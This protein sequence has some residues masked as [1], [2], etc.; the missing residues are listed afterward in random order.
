MRTPKIKNI[1]KDLSFFISN[2]KHCDMIQRI[3]HA[4]SVPE[5]IDIL[6]GLSL[7]SS[8]VSDI[9]QK[10]NLP[11]S[12]V[13]RH[14]DILE[15]AKLVRVS[16][17]PTKKGHIKY[18]SQNLYSYRV[19]VIDE[20]ARLEP[21][22]DFTTEMPIG[23]FSDIS[24]TAPCGMNSAESIIGETV[25]PDIFYLPERIKAER[26][27]FSSGHVT[28]RF[29]LCPPHQNYN[30]I[31]FSFEI[32]SE[33]FFFNP[34]WPSDVTLSINDIEVATIHLIGD[35]GGRLGKYTPK[36]WS[37]NNS[38]FGVLKTVTVNSTGVYI[39]QQP[40]STNVNF[41]KLNL[42]DKNY[43]T[44]T[45]AVKENAVHKGGLN[46]YGKN[47]GDYPQAIIMTLR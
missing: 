17:M 33:T 10:H 37:I 5:R 7:C 43:L 38:Q 11:M 1:E 32:C 25:N 30:E 34:N 45:F 44:L 19:S 8:S 22:E 27:W 47:C 41:N 29:P 23:M 12:S 2:K 14:L 20:S 31:S 13:S 4:L 9:A 42:F 15:D 18:Y 40:V 36:I 3:S 35:F 46:L 24:V 16:L 6:R 26:L 28:Y 21:S 39:D